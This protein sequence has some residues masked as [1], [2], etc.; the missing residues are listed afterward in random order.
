MVKL[1]PIRIFCSSAAMPVPSAPLESFACCTSMSE[2]STRPA[3][4][5]LSSSAVKNTAP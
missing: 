1:A 2:T 4:R 5:S 3:A